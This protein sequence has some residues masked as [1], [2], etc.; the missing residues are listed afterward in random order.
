MIGRAPAFGWTTTPL[1]LGVIA[2]AI[3]LQPVIDPEPHG[4]G[5]MTVVA[6]EIE[7]APDHAGPAGGIEQPPRLQ[8]GVAVRRAGANG[9][10]RVI[11]SDVE[12]AYGHAVAKVDAA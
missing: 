3:D 2:P 9:M 1:P 8:Y 5:V 11:L 10:Q 7:L 12:A 6:R 4:I